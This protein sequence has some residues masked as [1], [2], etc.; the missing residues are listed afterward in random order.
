MLGLD[1]YDVVAFSLG[2]KGERRAFAYRL[3]VYLL[4]DTIVIGVDQNNSSVDNPVF[5]G[6]HD[7]V[8]RLRPGEELFS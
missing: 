4:L 6:H 7:F 3:F 5:I 2:H 8:A 1:V